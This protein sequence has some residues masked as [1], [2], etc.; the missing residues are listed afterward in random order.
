[1]HESR[2]GLLRLLFSF[3]IASTV[4]LAAFGDTPLSDPLIARGAGTQFDPASAT[5]GRDFLLVWED[6]RSGNEAIYAARVAADGSVL[7]PEGILLSD[8]ES[9]SW[10]PSVA[11]TGTSY[12]VAWES[13]GCRFRRLTADGQLEPGTGRVFDDQCRAPRVAGVGGIAIIATARLSHGIQVAIIEPNGLTRTLGDIRSGGIANVACSSADC[14]LTWTYG[15]SVNGRFIGTRGERFESPDRLLATHAIG[16]DVAATADRFLL[17]WRDGSEWGS[18]AQHLW[19]RELDPRVDM[20]PF[21]VKK[22]RK[23]GI[24]SSTVSA[25]GRDF[26][27]SWTQYGESTIGNPRPAIR[28][29]RERRI[30]D[31]NEL[32]VA[33]SP[34]GFGTHTIASNGDAHVVAWTDSIYKIAAGVVRDERSLS[35]FTVTRTATAQIEPQV[36]NCDD[37]L[38]VVWSEEL[39]GAGK[40]SVLARRFRFSGEAID[41]KPI[42]IAASVHSQRRPA[43]AFDGQSYLIAWSEDRAGVYARRLHRDGTLDG[44]AVTL[45]ERGVDF[46]QVS[47]VAMDRGF[48][49]LYRDGAAHLSLAQITSAMTKTEI[50]TVPGRNAALA[51]NG[52]AVLAVWAAYPGQVYGMRVSSDGT[53]LDRTPM[54]IGFGQNEA[55]SLSIACDAAQCV[56]AWSESHSGVHTSLITGSSAFPV[57]EAIQE[58]ADYR[59]QPEDRYRPRV[60]RRADGY[61]VISAGPGSSLFTRSIQDGYASPEMRIDGKYVADDYSVVDTPAGVMIVDQR[62]TFGAGYAGARRLYLRPLIP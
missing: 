55:Q 2:A 41:A 28:E 10:A 48:A 6:S 22:T 12:I 53:V 45:S 7:D 25:S 24:I 17:V 57:S 30:G 37:H 31:D 20:E 8:A 23:A 18:P 47:V 50:T 52:T 38:L 61:Q 34:A 40:W 62:P 26:I 59:A 13:S 33:V 1:M 19:A 49:A 46:G 4:G 60:V 32:L 15:Q 39:S 16:A 54:E 11:W 44:E 27:V 5:N 14:L 43:A 9:R 42:E 36:V 29:M 21:V 51:W 3:V 35:R 56:V 58:L